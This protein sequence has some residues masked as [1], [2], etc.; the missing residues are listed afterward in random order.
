MTE[1]PEVVWRRKRRG[2]TWGPW[3]SGDR[4]LTLCGLRLPGL[5]DWRTTAPDDGEP[6]CRDCA[7]L[8]ALGTRKP[9]RRS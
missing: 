6:R 3:H 1:E 9:F 2:G 8:A 5:T 4:H 7:R